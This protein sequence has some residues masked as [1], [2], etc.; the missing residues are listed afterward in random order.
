MAVRRWLQ[1]FFRLEAAS[2]LI[3]I[4]ASVL[5]LLLANSAWGDAYRH[6]LHF[7]LPRIALGQ[8]SIELSL[9]HFINDGLMALFFLL[10]AAEIKREMLGGQLSDRRALM[11]PLL[12]AASGVLVPAL[13]FTAFNHA[14]AAAM[15]GW[16]V[17]TAT[18]IAFAL[19][20]LAVLG[21]RVP[22][23]L[24]LLLS[25]IAVVDDL[26]AIVIIAMFYTGELHGAS[27]IA[28]IAIAVAMALLNRRGVRS[29]WPYLLLGLALWIVVL[30][31]GVHATLAGVVTGFLIPH[32]T[33][34]DDTADPD[35]SPSPLLRLEDDLHPF[36]AYGV[37]PLFALANAGLDLSTTPL[38]ALTTALPMG[39]LLAL[40]IGKPLGIFSAAWLGRK[41]GLVDYPAGVGNSVLFGMAILCGIGFTMSLFI[42]S[43]AY[44]EPLLQAEATLGVFAASV[45]SALLGVWWLQRVLPTRSIDT[46]E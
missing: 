33:G 14:D 20:M 3:L 2:G 41:A 42:A 8:W 16:A 32:V 11:L 18:D 30:R 44:R 34:D 29:L 17:P 38:G 39:V 40:L 31:S 21:S 13:I 10:V 9:Q 27:L 19:A 22:L 46:Q 37:L 23:G 6:L 35:R 24:K 12:C 1:E 5:A 43:L 45:L 28:A 25:T 26:I 7:E 4:G 15:R 36:V